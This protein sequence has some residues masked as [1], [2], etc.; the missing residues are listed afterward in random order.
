MMAT[1]TF[2]GTTYLDLTLHLPPPKPPDLISLSDTVFVPPPAPWPPPQL[3]S[4][5]LPPSPLRPPPKPKYRSSPM[6]FFSLLG[7]ILFSQHRSPKFQPPLDHFVAFTNESW[8]LNES[9]ICVLTLHRLTSR[10]MAMCIPPYPF[11][12]SFASRTSLFSPCVPILIH[13]YTN[14]FS[15][16]CQM[17]PKFTR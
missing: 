15:S 10:H 6:N 5:S 17:F 12:R 11:S 2:K 9:T 16:T 14:H 4:V 13:I 8:T 3:V 7:F 1:L